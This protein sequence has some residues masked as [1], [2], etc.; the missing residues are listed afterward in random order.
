MTRPRL[1][2]DIIIDM[3]E[4]RGIEKCEYYLAS[5]FL[6]ANHLTLEEMYNI[7]KTYPLVNRKDERL[8]LSKI[9]DA[10]LEKEKLISQTKEG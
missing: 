1:I 4:K 7:I 3:H 9:Y 10:R 5:S 8:I 2:F 6:D